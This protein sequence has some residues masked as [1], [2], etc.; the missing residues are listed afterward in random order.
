MMHTTT[1]TATELRAP[2]TFKPMKRVAK[3]DEDHFFERRQ[4]KWTQAEC[5][6]AML[7]IEHFT[8][9]RLPGC[10]GGESLRTTLSE[11]LMCTPMRITKKL[12]AT[13]AIGKCCFKKKGELNAKERVELEASRAAFI[14]SVDKRHQGG[15]GGAASSSS[16]GMS[17]SSSSSHP[18]SSSSTTTTNATPLFLSPGAGP[19]AG[20]QNPQQGGQGE[21]QQEAHG[22]GPTTNKGTTPRPGPRKRTRVDD[23]VWLGEDLGDAAWLDDGLEPRGSTAMRTD[24]DKD[25]DEE[26]SDGPAYQRTASMGPGPWEARPC[27]HT[28][29]SAGHSE[30]LAPSVSAR[31]NGKGRTAIRV[32]ASDRPGLIGD[33]SR[34]LQAQGL[35]IAGCVAETLPNDV[36]HDEFDVVRAET[37]Q[38]VTEDSDLRRIEADLEAALLQ[39]ERG[40]DF[41]DSRIS[42][43]DSGA[44]VYEQ[45]LAS[46]SHQHQ[47]TTNSSVGGG[48]GGL[49]DDA[50]STNSNSGGGDYHSQNSSPNS[51]TSAQQRI[52]ATTLQVTVPDRPGLLKQ[53]TTSLASLSLSIVGAKIETVESTVNEGGFHSE[54]QKTALDT[55]D[56]VD[57]ESG[58]PVLDP[59]RLRAIEERL[60][61]D[62]EA[63]Q[64]V[65]HS[66]PTA[67][68]T[69]TQRPTTSLPFF[70]EAPVPATL[71]DAATTPDFPP[72]APTSQNLDVS[73]DAWLFSRRFGF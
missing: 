10:A 35:S 65:G 37:K 47:A 38:P 71:G 4:G 6:Y 13:H 70:N 42:S 49:H 55:F 41:A 29:A 61:R 25:N 14:A 21:S 62:L 50:S 5:N 36:A 68:G 67:S 31:L 63:H 34:A 12:S 20:A 44:G 26:R 22:D 53:I 33:I 60:A 19:G 28:E 43:K 9:G 58:G 2:G 48:G 32:V 52:S 66:S 16:H 18:A 30:P 11:C 8:S 40:G 3:K 39:S 1:A 51:T 54:Q 24:D 59:V 57:A 23:S 64:V 69:L 56:V 15:G 27:L 17:S 7:L 72:Y 73:D 45:A 46:S